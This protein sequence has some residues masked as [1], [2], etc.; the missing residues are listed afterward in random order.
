MTN[1]LFGFPRMTP[2]YTAAGGS[3]NATYP[4]ANLLSLPLSRVARSTN[5]LVA[6]T[7][8]DLTSSPAQSATTVSLA[9]HNLSGNAQIRVNCWADAARTTPTFVGGYEDVWPTAL[10]TMTA[11]ERANAV[12]TWFKRFSATP[13]TCGAI[14][15]EISDAANAAGYVQAGFAEVCQH[16]ETRWNFEWGMNWG[17]TFRSQVTE[18]IGGAQYVDRRAKPRIARGN[19]PFVTRDQSQTKFWEMW[20]QL[21]LADPLLFVPLY[22][23]PTHYPRTA[24]LA[25]QLDAGPARMAMRGAGTLID[26]VPFSLREIIG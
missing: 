22:D 1:C 19:F 20:R 9:R 7:V 25:Q 12:W 21:D 23:E 3:W 5:A 24:M 2:Y 10:K 14:R 4:V 17:F 11:A 16:F 6:S 13:I 26:S 18:A 8:I 15:L